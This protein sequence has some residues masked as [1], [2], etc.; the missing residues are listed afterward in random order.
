MSLLRV[1]LGMIMNKKS[2]VLDCLMMN[3]SKHYFFSNVLCIEESSTSLLYSET[4]VPL[5]IFLKIK[6][7]G[8]ICMHKILTCK[9]LIFVL[10]QGPSGM[11]KNWVMA[12]N[13]PDIFYWLFLTF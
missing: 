8:T 4:P 13:L 2:I 10:F 7:K 5:S 3:I 1:L 6:D 9:T 11:R 12:L